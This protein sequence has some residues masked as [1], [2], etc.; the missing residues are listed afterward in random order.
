MCRCENGQK[1]EE[2]TNLGSLGWLFVTIQA[3]ALLAATR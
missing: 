2:V 3:Q 1:P